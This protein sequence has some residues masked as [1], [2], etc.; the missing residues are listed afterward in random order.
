MVVLLDCEEQMSREPT[1]QSFGDGWDHVGHALGGSPLSAE[2]QADG[3]EWAA[4]HALSGRGGPRETGCCTHQ[5]HENNGEDHGRH[6][7]Q[8]H[9]EDT[10]GQRSG[11]PSLAWASARE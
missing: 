8:R 4:G 7:S 9:S 2:R 1:S 5:H 3:G 10:T 6:G 11:V